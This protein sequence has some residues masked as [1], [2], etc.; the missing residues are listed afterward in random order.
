[1]RE[2]ERETERERKKERKKERVR[3]TERETETQRNLDTERQKHG[4]MVEFSY[5]FILSKNCLM[6]DSSCSFIAS[7]H[8]LTVV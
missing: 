1:M 3:E 7:K 6:G 2:T 5:F 8:F 4:L